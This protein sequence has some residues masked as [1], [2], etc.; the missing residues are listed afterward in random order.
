L[1]ERPRIDD[2]RSVFFRRQIRKS[3]MKLGSNYL[4][5]GSHHPPYCLFIQHHKCNIS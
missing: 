1:L 5:S 3:L 4:F 2:T